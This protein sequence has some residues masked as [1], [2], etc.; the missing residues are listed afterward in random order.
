M[1]VDELLAAR[2]IHVSSID[3]IDTELERRGVRAI[4]KPAGRVRDVSLL[5]LEALANGPMRSR[6]VADRTNQ[7]P[8]ACDQMLSKMTLSGEIRREGRGVYALSKVPT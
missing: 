7:T 1:S 2:S 5:V 3:A 4:A 6:D 8:H